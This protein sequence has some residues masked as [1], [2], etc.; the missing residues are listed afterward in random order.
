MQIIS[1]FQDQF[2]LLKS[3]LRDTYM[4]IQAAPLLRIPHLHHRLHIIEKIMKYGNDVGVK[5][6]AFF[7]LRGSYNWKRA[8]CSIM[9]QS[10]IFISSTQAQK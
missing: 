5:A 10:M 2:E 9:S 6:V 1:C 4:H 3:N 8:N 7:Q